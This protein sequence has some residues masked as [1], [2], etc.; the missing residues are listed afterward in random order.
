MRTLRVLGVLILLIVVARGDD[1]VPTKRDPHAAVTNAIAFFR[2]SREPDALVWLAWMHRRFGIPEFADAL[3][4][5]DQVLL[6]QPAQAPLRR[7]LRRVADRGNPVQAEDWAAVLHPS[8]RITVSALYCDQLGLP[9]TFVDALSNAFNQG[10]YY[11]PHVLLAVYWINEN[12][13][14]LGGPRGFIDDVYRANA[15]IIHNDPSR[16]SD[17]TLEAGAF[18]YLAGQGALI[19]D[20]FVDHVIAAQNSDGGWGESPTQPGHSDWHSSVLGLL[21]LVH[22]RSLADSGNTR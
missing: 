11:F 9:A 13:C 2:G 5:Y 6:E 21:L 22:V 18:M 8:D 3:Q 15:A 17:L 20:A 4:R 16:V 19:D 12:G 7:V 10:G 14:K 1:F